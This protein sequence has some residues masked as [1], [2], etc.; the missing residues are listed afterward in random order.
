MSKLQLIVFT[1]TANN[2]NSDNT[3]QFCYKSAGS[4][5]QMVKHETVAVIITVII[6]VILGFNTVLGASLFGSIGS[7]AGKAFTK[8]AYYVAPIAAEEIARNLANKVLQPLSR[9]GLLPPNTTA[10]SLL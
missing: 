6:I 1:T 10:V 2:L 4:V 7:I 9:A 8:A 5:L 3:N